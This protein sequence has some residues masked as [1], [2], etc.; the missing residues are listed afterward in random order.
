[1]RLSLK[2]VQQNFQKIIAQT[3]MIQISH[4]SW[5]LKL[6]I[7]KYINTITLYPL[8]PRVEKHNIKR[9]KGKERI[10]R[11]KKIKKAI[12]KIK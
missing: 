3:K 9:V 12:E 5:R 10:K 2:V 6:E 1:M 7:F 4:Y 8:I 11:T